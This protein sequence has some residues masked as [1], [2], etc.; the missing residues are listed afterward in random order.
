MATMHSPPP[1]PVP[2]VS[3]RL[4]VA[5]D[6]ICIESSDPRTHGD[7]RQVL[8]ER[9][10]EDARTTIK[11]LRGARHQSDRRAGPAE[12][13]PT[14][15]SPGGLPYEVG[16]PAFTRELRQ[17]QWPSHRTFKADVGEKYNGKTH[18]VMPRMGLYL[19][20]V[21][22]RLKDISPFWNDRKFGIFARLM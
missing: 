5:G 6:A 10:H 12:N 22:A 20:R 8:Q 4:D 18:P 3:T 16:C 9:A 15:E 19:L 13:R 11:R 14:P 1:R 17:F 2:R 7:Q 21:E